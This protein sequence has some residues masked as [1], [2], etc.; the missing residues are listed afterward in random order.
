VDRVSG[1]KHLVLVVERDT[2]PAGPKISS[3][4]RRMSGVVL[5]MIV[6]SEK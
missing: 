2:E 5:V 6:A 1:G 3:P 4:K